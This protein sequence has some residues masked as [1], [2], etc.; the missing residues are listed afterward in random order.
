MRF[1][2]LDNPD[3]GVLLRSHTPADGMRLL[4]RLEPL[5][6]Q[7]PGVLERFRS[8][9]PAATVVKELVFDAAHFITDHP[10]KCSNLHG[11]RYV[12]HVK[13]RDRIDPVTG[14]VVDYSYNF[15]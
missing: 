3:G 2:A 9:T 14:C 11:G 13:V 8:V 6:A 4:E 15:V 1:E 12:L 7:M 10:A 5:L